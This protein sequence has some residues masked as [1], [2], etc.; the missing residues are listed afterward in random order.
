MEKERLLLIAGIV[1]ALL[2]LFF[3]WCYTKKSPRVHW[4][5]GGCFLWCLPCGIIS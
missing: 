1:F 5:A 2:M 3:G 4:P